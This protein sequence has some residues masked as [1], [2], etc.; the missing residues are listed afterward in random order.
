MT[1]TTI[2]PT[3]EQLYAAAVVALANGSTESGVP[4]LARVRQDVEIVL[5]K[6]AID[7][8]LEAH[9]LTLDR[10]IT[11]HRKSEA[12]QTTCGALLDQYKGDIV[13]M[14]KHAEHCMSAHRLLCE[15]LAEREQYDSLA[16][17]NKSIQNQDAVIK[18][19]ETAAAQR[20]QELECTMRSLD[21]ARCTKRQ[22]VAQYE[23]MRAMLGASDKANEHASEC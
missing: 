9:R 21:A 22:R 17:M 20:A 16:E 4:A 7:C 1:T 15:A 5:H 6:R 14:E 8:G 2:T 10:W 12:P 23:D 13:K 19:I 11:D 3:F 18:S